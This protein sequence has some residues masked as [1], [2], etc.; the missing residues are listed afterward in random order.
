VLD[1]VPE[2]ELQLSRQRS[3]VELDD[4]GHGTARRFCA[5]DVTVAGDH[6]ECVADRH[7]EPVLRVETDLGAAEREYRLELP[8]GDR[9]PGR[10]IGVDADEQPGDCRMHGR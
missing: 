9:S 5:V 4:P 10:A 8:C 7:H 6:D 2:S 3:R 1:E